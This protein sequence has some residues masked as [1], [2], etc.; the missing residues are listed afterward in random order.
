ME[1]GKYVDLSGD[2]GRIRRI[3]IFPMKTG[4]LSVNAR[5]GYGVL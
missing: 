4:K 3:T 2:G 5:Y 1:P